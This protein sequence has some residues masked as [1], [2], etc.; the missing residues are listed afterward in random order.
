MASSSGQNTELNKNWPFTGQS[1]ASSG[2]LP[3]VGTAM[4]PYG[5]LKSMPPPLAPPPPGSFEHGEAMKAMFGQL[6]RPEDQ[7]AMTIQAYHQIVANRF[8]ECLQAVIDDPVPK[9]LSG[10]DIEHLTS[11]DALISD[12]F[13]IKR[14]QAQ[15]K[16]DS[17]I[18]A[19]AAKAMEKTSITS[20]VD[21]TIC[22]R[23]WKRQAMM[24]L[25]PDGHDWRDYI[26]ICFQCARNTT[27]EVTGLA[28]TDQPVRYE[29][30]GYCIDGGPGTDSLCGDVFPVATPTA[31]LT[32]WVSAV[33]TDLEIRNLCSTKQFNRPRFVLRWSWNPLTSKWDRTTY[34]PDLTNETFA[35]IQEAQ[36]SWRLDCHHHW[37]IRRH[38]MAAK[39]RR[40]RGNSWKE[41][42]DFF[43]R[44]YPNE[45]NRRRAILAAKRTTIMVHSALASFR[46]VDLQTKAMILQVF[47]L[48]DRDCEIMTIDIANSL[49]TIDQDLMGSAYA[50]GMATKIIADINQEWIC[51]NPECSVLVKATQWLRN[52]VGDELQDYIA[53]H[54]QFWCPRCAKMYQPWKDMPGSDPDVAKADAARKKVNAGIWDA[55]R[56][57]PA[58]KAY[59]MKNTTGHS[60]GEANDPR[61]IGSAAGF[62]TDDQGDQWLVFLCEWPEITIDNLVSRLKVVSAGLAN[63]PPTSPQDLAMKM[64]KKALSDDANLSVSWNRARM[65]LSSIEAINHRNINAKKPVRLELAANKINGHVEYDYLPVNFKAG[66]TT[67]MHMEEQIELWLLIKTSLFAA[68]EAIHRTNR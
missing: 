35:Q 64:Y 6:H 32:E 10:E 2:Y 68:A 19:K 34:R 16:N 56:L 30:I 62:T 60:A 27:E 40:A 37:E 49:K 4:W 63:S 3:P 47:S 23:P 1:Q 8:R 57:I 55:K 17:A 20:S 52:I 13:G 41:M 65:T 18:D 7:D 44:L 25:T 11:P 61:S 42:L 22:G 38:M 43:R 59:L 48:H 24:P 26:R 66:Q 14:R 58:N 29:H 67:I 15:A 50:I 21:C 12:K 28:I 33:A 45:S 46:S 39:A 51:R 9:Q 53:Q 31:L 5:S 54:G 36:N